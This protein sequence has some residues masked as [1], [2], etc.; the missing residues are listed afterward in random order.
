MGIEEAPGAAQHGGLADWLAGL[1]GWSADVCAGGVRRGP[2]GGGGVARRGVAWRTE[3]QL[4]GSANPD[5][6]QPPA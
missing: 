2:G 1:A 4:G 5:A 6:D 3:C